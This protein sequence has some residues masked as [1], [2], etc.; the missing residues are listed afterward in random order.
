MYQAWVA[1]GN[2]CQTP[3]L[4]IQLLALRESSRQGLVLQGLQTLSLPSWPIQMAK[5]LGLLVEKTSWHNCGE[6]GAADSILR[7]IYA[8]PFSA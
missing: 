3:L 5:V 4:G 2:S 1:G 6:G 7:N 8:W